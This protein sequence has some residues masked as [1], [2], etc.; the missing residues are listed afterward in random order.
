MKV[1]TLTI[2]SPMIAS[3][4]PPNASNN[5]PV[6]GDIIP[7]TMAPGSSISPDSNGVNNNTFCMN[8]GSNVSAPMSEFRTAMVI[9]RPHV[10]IRDWRIIIT[11]ALSMTMAVLI[12]LSAAETMLYYGPRYKLRSVELETL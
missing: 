8:N 9:I 2:L 7:M 5:R 6:I 10:N 4:F 3:H 12:S 1:V 11:M